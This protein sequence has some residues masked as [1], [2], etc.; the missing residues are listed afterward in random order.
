MLNNE[1]SNYLLKQNSDILN[2]LYTNVCNYA[3]NSND[4]NLSKLQN[5]LDPIILIDGISK[6]TKIEKTEV[7]DYIINNAFPKYGYKIG[8]KLNFIKYFSNAIIKEHKSL[9]T[10]LKDLEDKETNSAEFDE[11]I[12]SYL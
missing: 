9:T 8:N 11:F 5:F 1:F 3:K 4:S 2:N 12:E 6:S 7:Y 10:L